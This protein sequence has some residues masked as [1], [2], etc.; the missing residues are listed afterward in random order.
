MNH[1]Q[2]MRDDPRP[3]FPTP[4]A[5]RHWGLWVPSLRITRATGPLGS[6]SSN[7][8]ASRVSKLKGP[9]G[10]LPSAMDPGSWPMLSSIPCFPGQRISP[11]LTMGLCAQWQRIARGWKGLSMESRCSCINRHHQ[12]W[13]RHFWA[14]GPRVDVV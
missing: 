13:V 5:S 12:G 4:R 3:Q 9:Q 10:H 1:I 11:V 6:I 8:W 2:T 7:T 14:G